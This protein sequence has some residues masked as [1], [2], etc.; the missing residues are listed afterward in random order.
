MRSIR[1]PRALSLSC[2]LTLLLALPL[3]SPSADARAQAS[4]QLAQNNQDAEARAQIKP[5]RAAA[6]AKKHYGGKVMSIDAR[7]RDGRVI[8][9]VKL[10]QDDGRLRQVRVDGRTGRILD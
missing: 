2:C 5:N 3:L 4:F 6:I 8:Y 9:R 10:L 1:W 7:E